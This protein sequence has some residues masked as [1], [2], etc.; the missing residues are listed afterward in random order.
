MFT[1]IMFATHIKELLVVI[2]WNAHTICK[3][4]CVGSGDVRCEW[5]DWL[6]DGMRVTLKVFHFIFLYCRGVFDCKVEHFCRVTRFE[7]MSVFI[8]FEL[9]LFIKAEL[10]G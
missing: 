1:K 4:V 2:V 8:Y 7:G 5:V 3:P 10:G 6:S 9:H